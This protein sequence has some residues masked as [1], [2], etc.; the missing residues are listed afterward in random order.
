M[1]AII[2]Q[3][4]PS[5]EHIKHLDYEQRCNSLI[6]SGYALWDVLARCDRPGSLDSRIVKA[7]EIPNDIAGFV[8]RH[9]ELRKIACNGRTAEK[10]FA[11]HIDLQGEDVCPPR[12]AITIHTLPSSSPAMASL[13]LNDKYQRWADGLLG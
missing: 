12:K 2:T 4:P 6:N 11:R 8:R 1:M 10:L 7:S 13:S 9:P 5:F 3:T